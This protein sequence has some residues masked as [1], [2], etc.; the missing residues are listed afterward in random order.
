MMRLTRHYNANDSYNHYQI[1][2]SKA[3]DAPRPVKAQTNMGGEE[4]QNTEGKA[5]TKRPVLA[6]WPDC[7]KFGGSC[8]IRTCD[9]RIKSP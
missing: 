4:T 3:I 1:Y 8:G 5:K 9:Q 7:Y 2:H 6:N